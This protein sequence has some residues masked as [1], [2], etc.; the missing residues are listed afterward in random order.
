MAF[1]L[2]VIERINLPVLNG[3][4]GRSGLGN[5]WETCLNLR[6]G[7]RQIKWMARRIHFLQFKARPGIT[8]LEVTI[9]VWFPPLLSNAAHF[10]R[11]RWIDK[12]DATVQFCS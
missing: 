12:S 1:R 6:R 9:C 8:T 11:E 7:R 4:P 3:S 2:S 10:L 5:V